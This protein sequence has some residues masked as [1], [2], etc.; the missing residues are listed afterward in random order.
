MTH[1]ICWITKLIASNLVISQ[2]YNDFQIFW[3]W[4]KFIDVWETNRGMET[5]I[6]NLPSAFR[7]DLKSSE[8]WTS[9]SEFGNHVQRCDRHLLR[10]HYAIL[11]WRSAFLSSASSLNFGRIEEMAK[12]DKRRETGK[13]S[14]AAEKRE[15]RCWKW[16]NG[17]IFLEDE[18]SVGS[19][20]GRV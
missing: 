1:I 17:W 9:Y 14:A 12:E 8:A 2:R 6:F 7:I 4:K 10:E 19:S 13:G 18:H 16:E 5:Y 20:N 15:R 3:N 11:Q